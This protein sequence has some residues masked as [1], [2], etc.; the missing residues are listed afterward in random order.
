M[1]PR[2]IAPT[3]CAAVNS[4]SSLSAGGAAGAGLSRRHA[5]AAA[6]AAVEA[7]N[8]RR[9]IR[10]IR[11]SFPEGT[12]YYARRRVPGTPAP[13]FP[14]TGRSAGADAFAP[15]AARRERRDV[16]RPIQIP[17]AV[18]EE[19]AAALRAD[20]SDAEQSRAEALKQ[21]EQRRM[22]VNNRLDRGYEE[23]RAWKL[24]GSG[25]IHSSPTAFAVSTRHATTTRA[26]TVANRQVGIGISSI[27]APVAR[28]DEDVD[29]L[30]TDSAARLS[31]DDFDKKKRMVTANVF[32][33]A[34][35][36]G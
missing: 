17:P 12:P 27:I 15:S 25:S 34:R 9:E 1:S 23:P 19:I 18:A 5:P 13:N 26:R 33:H 36:Q 30:A 2:A 29:R 11:R 14:Q 28:F 16:I 10:D 31:W 22:A 4:I 21:L 20:E 8:A 6:A 24:A 35:R 3:A 7:T 32:V